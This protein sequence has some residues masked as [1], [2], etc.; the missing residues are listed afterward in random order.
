LHRNSG[1]QDSEKSMA[2]REYNLRRG[3]RY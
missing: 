2:L 3:T 1:S